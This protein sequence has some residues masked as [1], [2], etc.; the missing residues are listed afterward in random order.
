MVSIR[1]INHC[2]FLFCNNN[3]CF[4]SKLL[5]KLIIKLFYVIL[6][7]IKNVYDTI[8]FLKED[9]IMTSINISSNNSVTIHSNE[10]LTINIWRGQDPQAFSGAEPTLT[11]HFKPSPLEFIPSDWKCRTVKLLKD[12][13]TGLKELFLAP[14]NGTDKA[15]KWVNKVDAK[16]EEQFPNNIIQ[17][18]YDFFINLLET[19][20]SQLK[21]IEKLNAWLNDNEL[22]SKSTPLYQQIALFLAKLPMRT[23]RNIFNLLYKIVKGLINVPLHPLRSVSDLAKL[24]IRLIDALTQP[25]T[26]SKLGIG[27]VGGSLGS[28][29]VTGNPLSALAIIIG[30]AMLVGGLAIGTLKAAIVEDNLKDFKRNVI[31]Q[32]SSLPESLLTGFLTGLLFGGIQRTLERT[33]EPKL[34]YKPLG[35]WGWHTVYPLKTPGMNYKNAIEIWWVDTGHG[36]IQP[37]RAVGWA[38]KSSLYQPLTE[39]HLI[40]TTAGVNLATKV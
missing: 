13:K 32:L 37:G 10:A 14:S 16:L 38:F 33:L 21:G 3:F 18:R 7:T 5:I 4:L 2:P 1:S 25:E 9:N 24:F 8:I 31:S 28:M 29:L 22:E 30:S 27:I 11:I 26:W 23:A 12:A 40:G 17:D 36:I 15:I 19:K 34:P 20:F 39:G 6:F 35:K